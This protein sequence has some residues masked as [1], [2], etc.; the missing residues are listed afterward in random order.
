MITATLPF[1]MIGMALIMGFLIWKGLREEDLPQ[2]ALITFCVL[3]LLATTSEGIWRHNEA[4]GTEIVKSASDSSF[5]VL[6]CNRPTGELLGAIPAGAAGW[7]SRDQPHIAN[8]R[9]SVCLDLMAWLWSDKSNASIPQ[10][11]ALGITIHEAV[12]VGGE[13]DEE[14]TECKTIDMY[15]DIAEEYGSSEDEAERMAFEYAKLNLMRGE[16]Y[17]CSSH[18]YMSKIMFGSS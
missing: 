11:D 9:Y 4:R 3:M 8:I 6:N 5:G 18:K 7:V 1:V 16:T 2:Q 10:I 12:H 15:A 17:L 14:W 13:Y